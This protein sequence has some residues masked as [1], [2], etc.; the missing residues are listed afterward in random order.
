MSKTRQVRKYQI[1]PEKM[2]EFV[3]KFNRLVVPVRR[4]IG[5]EV[6]A[7]WYNRQNGTFIWIPSIEGTVE[8]FEALQKEYQVARAAYRKE[9]GEDTTHLH[10]AEPVTYL[11]D[12]VAPFDGGPT[13]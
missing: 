12:T 10:L 6:E 8:E 11:V 7:A 2:D 4:R 13:S 5:F 3:D 1:V 9:V